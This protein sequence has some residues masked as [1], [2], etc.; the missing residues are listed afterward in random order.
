M[1]IQMWTSKKNNKSI[2]FNKNK[3]HI[4]GY[5]SMTTMT[6]SSNIFEFRL[7]KKGIKNLL[8]KLEKPGLTKKYLDECKKT[9]DLY[10]KPSE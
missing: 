1:N 5:I 6:N 10:K 8:S 7:P 9:A 3:I 2:K 4:R